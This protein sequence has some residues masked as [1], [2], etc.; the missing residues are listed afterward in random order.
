MVGQQT[1]TVK[2]PS[3]MWLVFCPEKKN[4]YISDDRSKMLS[5]F[6]WMIADESSKIINQNWEL[7]LPHLKVTFFLNV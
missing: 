3:Y 4:R 7:I 5:D 2:H 1:I 6:F